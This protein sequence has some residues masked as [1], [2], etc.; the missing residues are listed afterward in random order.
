MENRITVRE[1]L[2]GEETERFRARL[3]EVLDDLGGGG[4][5]DDRVVNQDN[6]LA[7]Y[8]DRERV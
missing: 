5:A 3:L 8:I 4:A 6:P 7:L 2:R 1:A